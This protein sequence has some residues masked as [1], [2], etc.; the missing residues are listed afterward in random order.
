M[1]KECLQ[2]YSDSIYTS[3]KFKN[4]SVT[5]KI[6][7][8]KAWPNKRGTVGWLPSV[9]VAGHIFQLEHIDSPLTSFSPKYMAVEIMI[10]FRLRWHRTY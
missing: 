5:V 10:T 4:A 8:L 3:G 6:D 2:S 9:S 1:C 7:L